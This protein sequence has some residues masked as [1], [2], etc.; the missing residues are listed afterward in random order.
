MIG[1]NHGHELTVAT[2]DLDA[3]ITK[4]YD[5]RGS[6]GHT[7]SVTLT[8]ANFQSLMSGMAVTVTSSEEPGHSH[9]ISIG[10]L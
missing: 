8:V 2:A 5:I 6:A 10:C 7:H 1:G 3:T 4:V 9:V